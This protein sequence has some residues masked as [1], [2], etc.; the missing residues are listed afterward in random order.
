VLVNPEHPDGVG[1]VGLHHRQPSLAEVA[2]AG[3]VRAALGVV[4]VRDQDPVYAGQLPDQVQ[5]LDPVRVLADLVDLVDGGGVGAGRA[6][7]RGSQ[8][9]GAPP[10]YDLGESSGDGC[11]APLPERVRGAAR[12]REGPGGPAEHGPASARVRPAGRRPAAT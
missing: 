11:A 7:C 9:E 8:H 4:E 5:R 12:T 1:Q 2:I 3:V 6:G 10:P